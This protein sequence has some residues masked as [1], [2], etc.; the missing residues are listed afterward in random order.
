[1]TSANASNL[2]NRKSAKDDTRLGQAAEVVE[3]LDE[4]AVPEPAEV[5]SATSPIAG[6]D[7]YDR[8]SAFFD[9]IRVLLILLVASFAVSYLMSGGESW[10]WGMRNKPRYLRAGWWKAKF[11]SNP[12]VSLLPRL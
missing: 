7:D 8:R 1:M 6:E 3:I 10:A 12:S 5:S 4:D 9:L 11:V 2:R